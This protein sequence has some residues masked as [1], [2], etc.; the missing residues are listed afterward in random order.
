MDEKKSNIRL[1]RTG[2]R[3]VTKTTTEYDWNSLDERTSARQ[4]SSGA[5]PVRKR[6]SSELEKKVRYQKQQKAKRLKIQRRRALIVF[7]LTVILVMVL[8]F[9]TPIFNIRSVS[10]EGNRLVSA[11]QFQEKL[12]PLVGENLLRTGSGKIRK[13]LKTIPYIDTVEVQKKL[14]PPSVKVTVTEYVPAAVIRTEG[15]S[16]LVNSELRVLTDSGEQSEPVPTVTG[17]GVSSY[18]TGE[19]LKTDDSDKKEIIMMALSTLEATGLIDK[20]IEI[21]V[22]D[23]ADVT[24]NYDNRITVKCGTQLDLE[25]KLRL[26]R[27]TVTSNSLAENARGTMDLSEPGRAVYTP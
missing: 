26:F 11:E 24:M 9:M 21:N 7:I 23:I 19:I 25:R 10:V 8:L 22:N 27:E 3:K 4:Q 17:F 16:L 20:V 1:V 5:A 15:S 12:K 13:T 18:K 6:G 2:G 14:F